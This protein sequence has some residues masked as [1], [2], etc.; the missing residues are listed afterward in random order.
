MNDRISGALLAHAVT[1]FAMVPLIEAC[2]MA[3]D[4]LTRIR[5][6]K[7]MRD[8]VVERYGQPDFSS[9]SRKGETAN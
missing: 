1:S 9:A 4:H 8:Q 2:A 3:P 5:I 7:T 6:G